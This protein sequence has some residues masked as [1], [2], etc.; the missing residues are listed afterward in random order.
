LTALVA[1]L[2]TAPSAGCLSTVPP[3]LEVKGDGGGWTPPVTNPTR[4]MG[5]PSGG[6]S[7]EA[8]D[9]EKRLGYQ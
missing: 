8:Q 5:R 4:R 9:I 2:L 1:A 7:G 6:L 3:A